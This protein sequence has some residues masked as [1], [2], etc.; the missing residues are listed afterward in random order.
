MPPWIKQNVSEVYE[1]ILL[2]ENFKEKSDSQ[3]PNKG[4]KAIKLYS[5]E[6]N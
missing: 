2:K 5:Q 4:K 3:N 6:I 1:Q